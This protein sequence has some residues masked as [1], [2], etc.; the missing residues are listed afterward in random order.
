MSNNDQTTVSVQA[1][2]DDRATEFRAMTNE[3]EHYSGTILLVSAYAILWA[4]LVAWLGVMWRRQTKLGARMHD[5]ERALETAT[6]RA[7]APDER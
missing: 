3:P 5:L 7:G 4:L 2:P 6:E 1:P